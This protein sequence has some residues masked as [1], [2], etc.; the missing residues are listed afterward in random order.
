MQ[1]FSVRALVI[2][3]ND[4]GE[5]DK[6]LTLLSD[7]K[8]RLVVRCRGSKSI[9]SKKLSGA[10]LFCYGDFTLS[11]SKGMLSVKEMHLIESF[12]A[13][14][15]DLTRMAL[16]N[17]VAEVLQNITT[18]ENDESDLL[19]LGLNTLHTLCYSGEKSPALIKSVFELRCLLHLGFAPDLTGCAQC[20]AAD[21]SPFYLDIREGTLLCHPCRTV[22]EDT[23]EALSLSHSTLCAMRY[24]LTAPKKRIFSFALDECALGKL[25]LL[26]ERFFLTQTETNYKTLKFYHS[27]L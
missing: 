16:A 18:E 27:I 21:G 19:T 22:A 5:Q 26:T 3:E 1:E 11:E 4:I 25:S 14:R 7:K 9:K 13:I 23:F 20:G 17:Y 6:L 15:E 12:Y 10:S 8:G 24:V 2:R